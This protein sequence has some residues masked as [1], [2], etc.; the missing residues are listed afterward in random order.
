MS[1]LLRGH[2][3]HVQVCPQPCVPP[4]NGCRYT[5]R[6][7][8]AA[9]Q[10]CFST[11]A[12]ASSDPIVCSVTPPFRPSR[13]PR[14]RPSIRSFSWQSG[15]SRGRYRAFRCDAGW[16]SP[17]VRS[18]STVGGEA[19][20][21]DGFADLGRRAPAQGGA[22]SHGNNGG[23]WVSGVEVLGGSVAS[24]ISLRMPSPNRASSARSSSR[25]AVPLSIITCSPLSR[26]TSAG[27][28]LRLRAVTVSGCVEMRSRPRAIAPDGLRM[29]SPVRMGGAHPVVARGG[30]PLSH[31]A[32]RQ[33]LAGSAHRLLEA[34]AARQAGAAGVGAPRAPERIRPLPATGVQ[35]A[36]LS[37]GSRRKPFEELAEVVACEVAVEEPRD[38]VA[39]GTSAR[40]SCGLSWCSASAPWLS[41]S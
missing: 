18:D 33:S 5:R 2:P 40:I 9:S 32:P 35:A 37:C 30:E 41:R 21:G 11:N 16:S 34:V 19:P 8:C 15:S 4:N 38:L 36:G 10:S 39:L 7:S 28:A 6:S 17:K 29:G 26:C 20:A 22:W 1:A 31:L 24:R 13:K 3:V 25:L 12:C 23:V 27:F 14:C